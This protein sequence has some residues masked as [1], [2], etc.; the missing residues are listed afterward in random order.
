MSAQPCAITNQLV[1]APVVR[2][3]VFLLIFLLICIYVFCFAL[4]LLLF[5]Y[6]LPFGLTE[7]LLHLAMLLVCF[8]VELVTFLAFYSYI[9]GLLL[10]HNFLYHAYVLHIGVNLFFSLRISFSSCLFLFPSLLFMVFLA[11]FT[12][13]L[14]VASGRPSYENPQIRFNCVKA[15]MAVHRCV[16]VGFV[17]KSI[18]TCAFTLM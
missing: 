13:S 8:F 7:R 18:L 15:D 9:S 10:F 5:D 6:L 3:L 11:T 12:A 14:R 4:F 2:L 16:C 17:C 1:D